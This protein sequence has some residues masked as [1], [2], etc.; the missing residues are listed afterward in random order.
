MISLLR[1]ASY[2]IGAKQAGRV[3]SIFKFSLAF[4]F[5]LGAI[6]T[7]I[8]FLIPD[9]LVSLFSNGEEEEFKIIARNATGFYFILFIAAGPNYIIAA[10]FQSIGKT[11]LS[12]LINILKSS[13]IVVLLLILLPQ[14]FKLGLN[15]VWLSRSFA[16]VLV[17]LV[18]GIYTVYNKEKYYSENTVN[19]VKS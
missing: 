4:T 10:Y 15:G 19:R 13:V 11:V 7:A 2:N 5:A 16:E 1:I 3:L 14:Y 6:V 12:S 17:L 9:L 18:I 8:G